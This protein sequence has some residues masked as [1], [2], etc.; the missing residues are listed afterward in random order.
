MYNFN[1]M[2]S[3]FLIILAILLLVLAGWIV[4]LEMRLKKFFEGS[5]GKD[6]ESI[7]VSVKEELNR[8]KT[9][10]EEQE[11]TLRA[12]ENKIK[13]S[14][15]HVKTLRFNPFDDSGSNQ[16]FAVALLDEEGSGVTLSSLYSRDKV[17][18]YAKPVEKYQSEFSLSE[19]EKE[20]I[21]KIKENE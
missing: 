5:K 15:Q 11:K 1:V 3:L 13:K 6:L 21:K 7:L 18:I 9:K 17:G 16:S 12:M 20:V 14:V 2:S 8:M 19:E 4:Y 10:E